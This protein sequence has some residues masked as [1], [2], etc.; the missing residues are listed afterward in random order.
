MGLNR[1]WGSICLD[2][3]SSLQKK[4]RHVQSES[5]LLKG[6]FHFVTSASSLG[7]TRANTD[8]MRELANDKNR[9]PWHESWSFLGG[10][11][12]HL[13]G[14]GFLHAALFSLSEWMQSLAP[15]VGDLCSELQSKMNPK[16]KCLVDP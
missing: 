5:G 10:K 2:K 6:K 7:C 16:E 13:F 14:P 9:G 4:G 8:A 3:E 15:G 11:W 12:T 1:S